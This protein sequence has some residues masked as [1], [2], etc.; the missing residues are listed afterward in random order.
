MNL[1][2]ARGAGIEQSKSTNLQGKCSD[3]ESR[4]N[5]IPSRFGD[6]ISAPG[7]GNERE[8]SEKLCAR[9]RGK[10]TGN[11]YSVYYIHIF[12]RSYKKSRYDLPWR[13]F[14]SLAEREEEAWRVARQ[15]YS[16]LPL[17][18]CSVVVRIG[19][20]PLDSTIRPS[21]SNQA[22]FKNN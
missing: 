22:D 14:N 10:A 3:I 5:Q 11:N 9:N 19:R 18:P 20:L 21:V 15:R 16:E 12:V 1:G 7:V 13:H 2:E 6:Q 8:C 4:T 17:S